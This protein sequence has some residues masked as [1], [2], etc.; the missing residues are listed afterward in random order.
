MNNSLDVQARWGIPDWT[1]AKAYPNPEDT[2]D[3]V[4]RWEFLRRRPDYRDAWEGRANTVLEWLAPYATVVADADTASRLLTRQLKFGVSIL[5][6]PGHPMSDEELREATVFDAEAFGI[7]TPIRLDTLIPLTASLGPTALDV[8][9]WKR[10]AL[11]AAGM[12]DYQFHLAEPLGP[13]IKRARIELGR[14]QAAIFGT[15]NTSRPRRHNWPMFLRALDAR[16]S[17]ATYAEMAV[18]FWPNKWRCGGDKEKTEQ[19]ARDTHIQAI[20]L[21]DNFPL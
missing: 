13:Q 3:L 4:W 6:D 18:K 9:C 7:A 14:R 1:E 10:Q 15:K 17:S 5:H 11:Q 8:L 19:S 21:R 16:D 12:V 2:T 20:R